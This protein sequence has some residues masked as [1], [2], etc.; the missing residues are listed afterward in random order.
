MVKK[1]H[2]PSEELAK[3]RAKRIKRLREY[4]R[5]SRPKLAEK[6]AKYGVKK[7]SL[8]N[9]ETARWYGLTESGAIMLTQA[10]QDEGL[11]VTIEYLMY[12]V[13]DDP[14]PNALPFRAV[15]ESNPA[16]EKNTIAKEL[17]YFHQHNSNAIDTTITD[18]GLD[19]HLVVGDYVAGIRYVDNDIER[20]IG[21]PSIV[22][23][24]TG[25]LLVRAVNCGKDLGFYTLSCTNPNTTVAKKIIKDI[26]LLS[27]API[28][29]IRKP[30][31]K[32]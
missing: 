6:Y 19:P 30:E 11:N 10:F 26:K 15:E 16:A 29:W 13:G 17:H 24:E 2:N 12:G 18:D 4:I 5:L 9:W 31:F 21:H 32:K 23:T 22:Q 28:L 7:N 3:A 1:P 20:A 14:I 25:E 8:Q 27:A